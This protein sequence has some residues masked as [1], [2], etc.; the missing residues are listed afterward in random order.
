MP[1]AKV[2]AKVPKSKCCVSKVRCKRCPVRMLKEG[3]LPVGLAVK[4]R[5]L[6]TIDGKRITKKK[7]KA[8]LGKRTD[9]GR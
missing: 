7:A 8:L 3:T 4:R 5:R 2:E 1:T 6:V 9:Q